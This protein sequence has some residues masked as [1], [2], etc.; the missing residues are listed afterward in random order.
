M[1]AHFFSV[2]GADWPT[3]WSSIASRN[4]KREQAKLQEDSGQM[5]V[6]ACHG[7]LCFQSPPRS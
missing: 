2:L 1:V 3:S 5:R 7:L 4:L 6:V